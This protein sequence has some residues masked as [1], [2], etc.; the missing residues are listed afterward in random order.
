VKLMG[1]EDTVGIR[2]LQYL[3]YQKT[4]SGRERPPNRGFY[5]TRVS[6]VRRRI[7]F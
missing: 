4:P 7:T 5:A 6:G 3:M 2:I 1:R